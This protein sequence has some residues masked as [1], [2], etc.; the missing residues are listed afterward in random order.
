MASI[1]KEGQIRGRQLNLNAATATRGSD[2]NNQLIDLDFVLIP[3]RV[4]VQLFVSAESRFDSCNQFQR[5]ERLGY[6]IIR[7][8]AE[9]GDLVNLLTWPTA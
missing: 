9:S 5:A 1:C 6:V 7:A 3:H 4:T 8:D 2:I